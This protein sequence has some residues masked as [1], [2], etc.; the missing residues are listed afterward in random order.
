ML[1]NFRYNTKIFKNMSMKFYSYK[2]L[3]LLNVFFLLGT[4]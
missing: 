1:Y 4:L 2:I 3:H